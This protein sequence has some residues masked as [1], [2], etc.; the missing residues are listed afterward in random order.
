M[1]PEC[2]FIL[3]NGKK[4]RCAAT[5]HQEFCR[6]HGP[7]PAN[8]GPRPA[9]RR[10]RYTDH[11]KW[12][13]LGRNLRW[14]DPREIPFT[15]HHILESMIRPRPERLSDLVAGRYL[16]LLLLRLGQV[17]FP[18]PSLALPT[19]PNVPPSVRLG[20]VPVAN[21][22]PSIFPPGVR[23]AMDAFC[24]DTNKET[25]EAL[26]DAFVKGGLITPEIIAECERAAR[27]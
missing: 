22:T 13:A 3:S 4:C 15:V 16:R 5:R 7:K 18:R 25:G 1:A 14:L 19:H 20:P 11:A 17:P 23:A 12:C 10:S 24:I 8:A 2:T 6:H 26:Y 27:T 9:A 21:P